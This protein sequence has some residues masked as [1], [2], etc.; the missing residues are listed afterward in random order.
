MRE[1][2]PSRVG[3][4][5]LPP[6]GFA[7]ALGRQQANTV[8][9][10]SYSVSG[11]G[12]RSIHTP[13]S[14]PFLVEIDRTVSPHTQLI[15]GRCRANAFYPWVDH[16]RLPSTSIY[17]VVAETL[18][19]FSTG[20]TH[21]LC[22]YNIDMF[23]FTATLA[24]WG[25]NIGYPAVP[26]NTAGNVYWILAKFWLDVSGNIKRLVQQHQGTIDVGGAG[27]YPGPFSVSQLGQV[28]PSADVTIGYNR[29]SGSL[30]PGVQ[31]WDQV[32]CHPTVVTQGYHQ[33]VTVTANG[34][35][36]L[37]ITRE[38]TISVGVPA[39]SALMPANNETTYNVCLA[40]VSWSA[41][42]APHVTGIYQH[43][44][45]NI[46]LDKTVLNYCP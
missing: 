14:T 10:G 13:V 4:G 25:E 34:Y 32:V 1:T 36:Y 28:L 42:P 2:R 3:A 30:L 16:L 37:P 39:F 20:Y 9:D 7:E 44:Y 19:V 22:G 33:H 12:N 5:R 18:P 35:I 41:V 31:L 40:Q 24:F 26:L 38:G 46:L 29:D 21:Y 6:R 8:V 23:N 43:Q 11:P 27:G 17:K 15:C 45:G